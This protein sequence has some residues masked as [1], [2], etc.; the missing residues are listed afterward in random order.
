MFDNGF[1]LLY[2]RRKKKLEIANDPYDTLDLTLDLT[3]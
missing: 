2:E 3:R 1:E